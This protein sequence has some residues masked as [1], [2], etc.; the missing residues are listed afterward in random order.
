MTEMAH[1]RVAQA[2]TVVEQWRGI[3]SR[4]EHQLDRD[5]DVET[6]ATLR[7]ARLELSD[8]ESRL[9]DAIR[10]A[11]TIARAEASAS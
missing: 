3:V 8:A 7:E 9:F 1:G 11:N 5:M 6:L 2:R 10:L 4:W